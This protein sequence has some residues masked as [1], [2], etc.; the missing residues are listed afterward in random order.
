[1]GLLLSI[2]G[3][4]TLWT[5][6]ADEPTYVAAATGSAV[7]AG[8]GAIVGSQT[9]DALGGVAI[10][11]AAGA[12]AGYAI[13]GALEEREERF[14]RQEET[15]DEQQRRLRAQEQQ[16]QELRGLSTDGITFRKD[17]TAVNGAAVMGGAGSMA[18]TRLGGRPA[19]SRYPITAARAGY[20]KTRL[21]MEGKRLIDPSTLVNPFSD[22]PSTSSRA[23]LS[24][25]AV[26]QDTMNQD[27][28]TQEIGSSSGAVIARVPDLSQRELPKR[29]ELPTRD[30]PAKKPSSREVLR[31]AVRKAAPL[32]ESTLDEEVV[33]VAKTGKHELPTESEEVSVASREVMPGVVGGI[34]V[35]KSAQVLPE[36]ALPKKAMPQVEDGKRVEVASAKSGDALRQEDTEIEASDETARLV[37]TTEECGKASE[38]AARGNAAESTADKLFYFRRALRLC[39]DAPE[40][41]VELGRVYRSLGRHEDA[42]FEYEEALRIQPEF[43][44]AKNGLEG[45][46][47]NLY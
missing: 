21:G 5:D 27:T 20:P 8:L 10:G 41:H 7:G 38:E 13:G 1:M 44:A 30:I 32:R 25:D 29:T 3:C 24:V 40:W 22:T 12:G 4:S 15:L 45:L 39:P 16:I 47:E 42:K 46:P 34:A 14:R 31:K 19:G 23:R 11:A 26:D 9:G 36:R 18:R 37:E 28:V 35:E 33:A 43:E 17:G 2:G 6:V